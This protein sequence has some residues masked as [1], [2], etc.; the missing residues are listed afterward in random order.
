[1]TNISMSDAELLKFAIE[2]GMLDAAYVQ[3][4][5]EMQKR[6][7]LL[8]KHPYAIWEG[9]NQKWYTYLPDKEKG[10]VLKK[11]NTQQ[12]IEDIVVDYWAEVAENPTV[13]ELFLEWREYK[14]ELKEIGKATYDR[15]GVDFQRFFREFGKRRIKSISALEVEDFLLRSIAEYSLTAKAF[16]N[17]RT[18]IFGIF[19]RAKKKK[20]VDFSITEVINDMEIGRNAF[21][22]TFKEDFEEV[23]MEDEEPV[24]VKY[25]EENPDMLNLGLLLLFKTGM[26][27]GELVAI[28]YSDIS[29]NIIRVRRTETRYKDENGKAVFRVKETPKTTAG[30]REVIIPDDYTWIVRKMRVLNPFGEYLMMKK[31]K[32]VRTDAVRKRLYHVCEKTGVHKKSPHK[33]RKTYG[34]ILLDNNVDNVL[35]MQQMGHTDIHCT[36]KHYHRNRRNSEAK[37]R[38]LSNIPEL[39]AK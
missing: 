35:I 26:R 29:D 28:K 25:L 38:I 2:N 17:L 23:F 39:M 36:E 32:R 11:R 5:I 33:I 8:K 1:M 14:L 4:K 9:T 27:V 15:Y 30:I 7:E 18:L 12:E 16:S 22:T 19:K 3:E 31:D 13:E 34:S 10:R 21:K 37:A 20:Y 24:V 6:E